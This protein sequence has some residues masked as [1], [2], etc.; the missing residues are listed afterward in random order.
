MRDAGVERSVEPI[1]KGEAQ[2]GTIKGLEGGTKGPIKEEEID[3]RSEISEI[4]IVST[5]VVVMKISSS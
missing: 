4:E 3:L 5:F 1:C 2:E